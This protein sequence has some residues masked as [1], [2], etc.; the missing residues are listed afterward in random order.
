MSEEAIIKLKANQSLMKLEYLALLAERI[1]MQEIQTKVLQMNQCK[2]SEFAKN[3][4]CDLLR[5]LNNQQLKAVN[6]RT[7]LLIADKLQDN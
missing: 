5:I 3:T 7:P 2:T 1:W 4:S 6:N